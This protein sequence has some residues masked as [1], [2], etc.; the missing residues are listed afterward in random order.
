MNSED[1]PVGGNTNNV[2]SR[3]Q[4]AYCNYYVAKSL[5][6]LKKFDEAKILLKSV[7]DGRAFGWRFGLIRKEAKALLSSL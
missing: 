2:L 5:I 4:L 3:F 6:K 7:T 1:T